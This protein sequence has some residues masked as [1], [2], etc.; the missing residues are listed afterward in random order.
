ML[1]EFYPELIPVGEIDRIG[2]LFKG[3]VEAL[4]FMLGIDSLDQPSIIV[5]IPD[6]ARV[7]PVAGIRRFEVKVVQILNE[8]VERTDHVGFFAPESG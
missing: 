6:H 1:F 8:S 7:A 2:I 3:V 5:P 4:E